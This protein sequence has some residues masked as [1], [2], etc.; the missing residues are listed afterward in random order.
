MRKH[1]LTFSILLIVLPL[2]LLNGCQNSVADNPEEKKT[3][4]STNIT[5]NTTENSMSN[6]SL[7]RDNNDAE[8]TDKSHSSL[9]DDDSKSNRYMCPNFFDDSNS[10][11]KFDP[12]FENIIQSLIRAYY[13]FRT[14]D[15]PD[16][17]KIQSY[18]INKNFNVDDIDD[19]FDIIV[20]TY[21]KQNK[22]KNG[23]K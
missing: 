22:T 5:T 12:N 23:D 9:Q 4:V 10:P 6:A 20:S 8:R 1:L 15:V 7:N 13:Y 17:Y 18:L 19:M 21:N 11:Y 14:D 3:T 16:L 2:G